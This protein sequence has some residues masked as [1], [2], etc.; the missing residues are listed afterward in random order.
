MNYNKSLASLKVSASMSKGLDVTSEF[1]NLA[2]GVPDITPPQ[3]VYDAISEFSKKPD[4]QYKATK[5][6]LIAL[7][8]FHKVILEG[9]LEIDPNENISFIPGAKYGVYLAL[10]T[11]L[12][13]GDNVLIIEPY[14]VSYPE[15]IKSLNANVIIWNAY[16][17]QD[18]LEYSISDLEKIY[19]IYKI[20]AIILNQ[21]NNPS[22]YSYSKSFI[23][24]INNLA[25]KYGSWLIID[26]VYKDLVFLEED[27]FNTNISYENVI[28]IG[29]L[30][31]SLSIPGLRI[32]YILG[33]A[34][35]IKN[36]NLYNQHITTC[37]N[38]LS[39]KILESLTH[40]EYL[41]FILNA[42]NIYKSRYDVAK[43]T[44]KKLGLNFIE[45]SA[46]F[47][48]LVDVSPYYENGDLASEILG[49]TKKILVTSG[50]A[51]G[52]TFKNYLRLCLTR[53]EDELT[54]AFKQFKP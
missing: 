43:E 17:N 29:S 40:N 6:S 46:G 50:S 42:R 27:R 24:D 13:E 45:S 44:F 11:I 9:D 2:I 14:W 48:G 41:Q 21:P 47:Y 3:F 4:L 23:N 32:G 52:N 16:I 54:Y 35:F 8:T 30:S 5:G 49:S 25:I 36:F 34:S 38:T 12:N 10:K 18:R 7:Q 19:S 22:G 1:I 20:K 33:S 28:R 37:L 51:Y 53:N 26:E 15:I 31:K 39:I